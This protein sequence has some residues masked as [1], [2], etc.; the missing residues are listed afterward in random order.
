MFDS[1][2]QGGTEAGATAAAAGGDEEASTVV[3]GKSDTV[4]L[5][6]GTENNGGEASETSGKPDGVSIL[7]GMPGNDDLTGGNKAEDVGTVINDEKGDVD[8]TEAIN[9]D[10]PNMETNANLPE[11]ETL[12]ANAPEE[13]EQNEAS[14]HTKSDHLSSTPALQD[15]EADE[16]ILHSI[17]NLSQLENIIVDTDGRFNSKDIATQNT[18]KNFRGIRTNQDLGSLF[19]MREEFFVYK[20]PRIVKDGKKTKR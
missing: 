18:W 8:P 10:S 4:Q 15:E 20:H 2:T 9:Q 1:G 16:D 6:A 13:D 14:A 17:S 11:N 7:E 5:T 12:E 3:D 19:E